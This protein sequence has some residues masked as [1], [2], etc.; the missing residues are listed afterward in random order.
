M[1]N[2]YRIYCNTHDFQFTWGDAPPT[3]CPQ[4]AGDSVDLTF[5]PII[6]KEK[7]LIAITPLVTST[8]SSKNILIGSFTYDA[9]EYGVFRRFKIRSYMTSNVTSYTFEIY[10]RTKKETV[11]SGTFSNTNDNILNVINMGSNIPDSTDNI[12][13][14]VKLD[15]GKGTVYTSEIAVF[16]DK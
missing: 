8:T 11:N 7:Q 5:I 2:L 6:R 15:G 9:K 12:E 4:N 10:N 14:Y 13:I 16:F 1:S 3:Q